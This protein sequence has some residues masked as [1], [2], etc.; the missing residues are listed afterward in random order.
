MLL[1]CREPD[2]FALCRIEGAV[3]VPLGQIEQ[4]AE[5]LEADDGSRSREIVVYCHHGRRSVRAATTLRAL[6]FT[7]VRSM[8]GGID[9]WSIDVD[10]A[11]ARY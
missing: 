2:E 9:V 8:A 11:V 7:N 3:L 6:G 1:D 5:E 4:R 10:S